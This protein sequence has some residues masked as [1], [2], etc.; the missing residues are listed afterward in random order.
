MKT[1]GKKKI[2]LVKDSAYSIGLYAVILLGQLYII[3]KRMFPS[4]PLTGPGSLA[5]LVECILVFLLIVA[6]ILTMKQH[7][8]REASDEL[9]I[10]NNYKAGYITKYVSVFVIAIMILLVKDFRFLFQENN[11]GNSMSVIICCISF[12]ELIHNLVFVILEKI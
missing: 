10:S 11:W 1:T 8:N 2:S 12:T 9:S 4:A 6:G 5:L 7:R 3:L